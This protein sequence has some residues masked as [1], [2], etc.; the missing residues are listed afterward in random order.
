[1]FTIFVAITSFLL[2]GVVGV[3]LMAMGQAQWNKDHPAEQWP[4]RKGQK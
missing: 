2:G 1:M 4:P 3:V